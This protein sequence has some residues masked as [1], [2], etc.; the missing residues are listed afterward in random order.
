MSIISV[1]RIQGLLSAVE[2]Y[3]PEIWTDDEIESLAEEYSQPYFEQV[4]CDG[5]TFGIETHKDILD[6]NGQYTL[7]LTESPISEIISV[8]ISGVAIDLTQ[9]YRYLTRIACSSKFPLGRKNVVV[10]YK[11]GNNSYPEP[12]I[13]A[14][15]L[16]CASHIAR[17]SGGGGDSLSTG[18]T[19]GPVSLNEAYS[20]SG[21][22]SARIRDWGI[23]IRNIANMYSGIKIINPYTKHQNR[24]S[25][26][27]ARIDSWD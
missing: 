17:V 6:G 5:K 8:T 16:L 25:T 13:M 24:A 20:S 21:K 10:E 26:Y 27:N 18:I 2:D 22:Y 1:E 14:I 7:R 23:K 4:L 19:A 9:I 12:A 11:A 3:D 15:E